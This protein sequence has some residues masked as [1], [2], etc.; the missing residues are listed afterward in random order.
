MTD[1]NFINA[2]LLT[3]IAGM[4]TGVGA[5]I[6]MFVRRFSPKVLSAS[7]GFSAGVMILISLVELF[8][9]ARHSLG[10]LHGEKLGMLYTLL[11]FFGGMAII[12]LIDHLVPSYENPHEVNE[13]TIE[14]HNEAVGIDKHIPDRELADSG[15]SHGSKKLLRLGLLSSI[16]IAVH[17][18]PEGLATFVTAMED[19][20]LGI[21]ITLAI[22]LHNIPEGIAVAI[23]IY[24][25]TKKRSKAVFNASL[26]GLAEPLG[27]VAGYFLLKDLLSDS[28]LGIILAAVAGIMVYISLDELLPTAENYGAHHIAIIGVLMGMAFMGFGMMLV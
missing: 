21:S 4:A 19:P 26:S 20:S 15:E 28:F 17:N 16:V 7:L 25:A 27:G 6:I 1:G 12:A 18:F 9:E 10:E 22:A 8:P 3:L 24:Y 2:L 11:A 23:P 5:A 13:L 14:V